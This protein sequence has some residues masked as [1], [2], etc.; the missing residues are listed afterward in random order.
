MPSSAPSSGDRRRLLENS[1]DCITS[2]DVGCIVSFAASGRRLSST[3]IEPTA[4]PTAAPPGAPTT[5]CDIDDEK[6]IVVEIKYNISYYN[7]SSDVQQAL[8]EISTTL[9]TLFENATQ[10]QDD[11]YTCA[12]VSTEEA[13]CG[14]QTVCLQDEVHITFA[15]D[16]IPDS[17]SPSPP[18]PPANPPSPPFSPSPPSSPSNAGGGADLELIFPDGG[19]ADFR[20][21]DKHTYNFLSTKD[22]IV[23]GL[24]RHITFRRLHPELM[25][26][27][28]VEGSFLTAI[29]ILALDASSL[30]VRIAYDP[31]KTFW[32]SCEVTI[33]NGTIPM[34]TATLNP[35][36]QLTWSLG[37]IRASFEAN[38]PKL[39]VTTPSWRIVVR[40]MSIRGA[41]DQKRL[42]VGVVSLRDDPSKDDVAPH[43]LLGQSWDGDNVTVHG[44]TDTS[45]FAEAMTRMALLGAV[46]NVKT[47]ANA[48]GA[49]EGTASDYIVAPPSGDRFST[50]FKYSRF[51]LS[52]AAPRNIN[53]LSGKKQLA[54]KR[55]VGASG[56]M[57]S[58][59]A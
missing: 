2:S 1:V 56:F 40:A 52:A 11:A 10:S 15:R 50:H 41:S 12:L 58:L 17:P 46:E 4:A 18:F 6:I 35:R 33:R 43:G 16:A 21:L 5:A 55:D 30:T 20:A 7:L 31:E 47:A 39:K 28:E 38:Q 27:F 48:E 57:T 25:E 59:I 29:Y 45:L 23:N 26:F 54:G 53:F 13:A 9:D 49:I 37:G 8:D 34:G 22:L 42:D 36:G 51:G 3:S 19:R 32:N 14:T 44:T 24:M